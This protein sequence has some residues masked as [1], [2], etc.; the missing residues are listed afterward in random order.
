VTDRIHLKP[1]ADLAPRVLLPGDP[2]RALLIA[3]A[4]LANPVM[5]NHHRGLWGYT[6]RAA[7]GELLTVQSTGMGGPS[8]AIVAAELTE[9]GA[10][11]LL[12]VGTCGALAPTL[13]LGDLVIATQALARDGA[14]QALGADDAVAPDA[15][16]TSALLALQEPHLVP[17]R[18]VSTDLFYDGRPG[19]EQAWLA[20]GAAAVEMESAALFTLA[21]RRGVQA[22]SLLLVSDLLLPRRVRI[23]A[24]A[25]RAGELRLGEVALRALGAFA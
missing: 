12:R 6:G 8:L 23:D 15:A 9:L 24:E 13:G 20:A 25:L 22:A 17:G 18:V 21:G 19:E 14:S 3:Q 7:D 10:S 1:T 5:F 4:L 11:R 16:L 2:G